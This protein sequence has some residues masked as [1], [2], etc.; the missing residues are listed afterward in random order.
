MSVL[1]DQLRIKSAEWR[2]EGFPQEEF[3]AIAEIIEWASAPDGSGFQLRPPQLRALE[4]YWF[5][6]LVEG[7][8][9]IEHLYKKYF[10]PSQEK[11]ALLSALGIPDGAW[12]SSNYDGNYPLTV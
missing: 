5:L 6:R 2:E 9:K 4:V 11:E 1:F 7:T 8:P 10:P 3:T 12:R